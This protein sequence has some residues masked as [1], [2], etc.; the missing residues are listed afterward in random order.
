M[1]TASHSA[2]TAALRRFGFRKLRS[3]LQA[4]PPQRTLES[5]PFRRSQLRSLIFPTL[6]GSAP[7]DANTNITYYNK[8][9]SEATVKDQPLFNRVAPPT[10]NQRQGN[11]SWSFVCD[12][13]QG[14]KE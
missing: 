4:L 9:L 8:L 1:R 7:L 3:Q 6:F 10:M 5:F 2:L 11:W 12:L 13:K 14:E